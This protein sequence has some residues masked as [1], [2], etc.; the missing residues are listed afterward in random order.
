MFGEY[1]GDKPMR[2]LAANSYE[3]PLSWIPRAATKLHSLWL[4]WTYPFACIGNHFSVHYSSEVRRTTARL[5]E[6][7]N[8]VNIGRDAWINIPEGIS[9]AAPVLL[10]GD[11]CTVGRRCVISAKNLIQIEHD[12]LFVPSALVMDHNHVY[13]DV[14]IPVAH[15]GASEG[16]TIRIEEGRW[17]GF[18]AVV[19]CGKGELV[20]GRNSL[21]GANSV[22]T[23]SVPPYSVVAENP[24]KVV[25]QFGPSNGEWDSGAA[26][27][28]AQQRTS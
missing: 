19:V 25:K 18:G 20:I 4:K 28:I 21:V 23:R 8:F 13:G 24:A 2:N 6:I 22:V 11:R 27:S 15:Q 12:V 26:R 16:G 17:L 7:G 9:S 14:T 10:L 1:S 3:D 5:I